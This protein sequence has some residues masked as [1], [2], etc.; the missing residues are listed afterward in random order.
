M[1]KVLPLMMSSHESE[2]SR[3]VLFV[4]LHACIALYTPIYASCVS[5]SRSRFPRFFV[6]HLINSVLILVSC[7]VALLHG[8]MIARSPDHQAGT[9]RGTCMDQGQ[10]GAQGPDTRHYGRFVK[11]RDPLEK[12]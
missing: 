5:M 8:Q 2:F 9:G 11:E 12:A 1:S 10:L 4:C 7:T 6:H 3:V